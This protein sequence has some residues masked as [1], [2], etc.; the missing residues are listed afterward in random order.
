[1]M[2]DEE[3]KFEEIEVSHTL[4]GEGV[5]QGDDTLLSY[6]LIYI[7]LMDVDKI[8]QGCCHLLFFC[9]LLRDKTRTK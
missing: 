6:T 5:S 1:M 8:C 7:S 4:S 2:K 3:I 9:L